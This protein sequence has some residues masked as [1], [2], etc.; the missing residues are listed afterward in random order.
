M[1]RRHTLYTI[2]SAMA[3]S[4]VIVIVSLAYSMKEQRAQAYKKNIESS[5]SETQAEIGFTL[6]LHDGELAVFR[7]NSETPYRL[8]GIS[9]SV[10]TEFDRKQLETGIFVQT[11][12][13]LDRLI[14]DYTS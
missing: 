11:Q 5:I 14:E 10:M 7:G 12:K 4:A 8:L 1:T 9:E 3:V 13:E 2:F 6:K